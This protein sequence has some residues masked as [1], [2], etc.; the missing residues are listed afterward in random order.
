MCTCKNCLCSPYARF[1]ETLANENRLYIL[2]AL[3]ET[4]K[5]VSEITQATGLEQ[6]NVSH[7]L[8][9]LKTC[10]FVT[11]ERKGKTIIYTLRK[12]TIAPLLDHIEDHV[13]HYC[14]PL[15]APCICEA[16]Q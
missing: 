2:H 7:N 1:F 8:K 10:G 11:S 9:R 3:R 14:R 16:T 4:P 15:G 6:T 5:S 12:D 13:N